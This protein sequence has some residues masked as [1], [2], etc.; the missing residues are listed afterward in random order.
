MYPQSPM[1]NQVLGSKSAVILTGDGGLRGFLQW[2]LS[3]WL[4]DSS[5]GTRTVHNAGP[6]KGQ[7][8]FE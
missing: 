1:G 3:A 8:V 6:S 2:R 4:R 5:L 7:A